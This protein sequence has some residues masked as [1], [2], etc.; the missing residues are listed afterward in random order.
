[1]I[2][3]QFPRG[4]MYGQGKFLYCAFVAD[5]DG[6]GEDM[7]FKFQSDIF[8][9]GGDVNADEIEAEVIDILHA[10]DAAYED[11]DVEEITIFVELIGEIFPE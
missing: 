7:M 1:M 4:P 11:Y 3:L 9:T 2:K 10:I 8:Y 6:G 5:P